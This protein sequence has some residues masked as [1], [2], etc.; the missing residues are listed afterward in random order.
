MTHTAEAQ[1]VSPKQEAPL[2][3]PF[4]QTPL[5]QDS[6]AHCA[7]EPQAVAVGSPAHSPFWQEPETQE[8]ALAHGPPLG[9]EPP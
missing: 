1:S 2:G 9:T 6:E 3:A 4:P 5:R 8:A 7:L